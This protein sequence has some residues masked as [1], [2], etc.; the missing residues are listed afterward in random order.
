M[1]D[2]ICSGVAGEGSTSAAVEVFEA[3]A[4][5]C[6]SALAFE[7]HAEAANTSVASIPRRRAVPPVLMRSTLSGGRPAR[8]R[9]RS[10]HGSPSPRRSGLPFQPEFLHEQ[11]LRQEGRI[12]EREDLSVAASERCD[13]GDEEMPYRC[14]VPP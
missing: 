4:S 5:S 10:S 8:I 9:F 6:A 3:L 11:V 14:G 7:P 2:A 1:T 12:V 13:R